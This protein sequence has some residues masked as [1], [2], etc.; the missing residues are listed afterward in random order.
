MAIAG[1]HFVD[2]TT[3]GA[4]KSIFFFG[5]I[6][7]YV[8]DEI[9]LDRTKPALIVRHGNAARKFFYLGRRG[10]V[11][12]RAVECDIQ[13]NGA[14][15]AMLH[16]LIT[17]NGPAWHIRDLSGLI[18]TRINGEQI[19]ET[20]L[21]NGDLLQIGMFAFEA[22]LPW[23]GRGN[24]ADSHPEGEVYRKRIAMLER[25]RERL[26]RLARRLRS[27]VS[28]LRTRVAMLEIENETAERTHEIMG[29]IRKETL[30]EIE[31]PVT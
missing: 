26:V 18:G 1:Y 8:R 27:R 28:D 29:E 6:I 13:L 16:S 10:T 19:K 3:N 30:A 7:M 17:C 14:D 15:I 25:A 12:G 20:Q 31:L 4:T 22:H 2:R 11:L 5:S 24:A 23:A 21:H 9:R